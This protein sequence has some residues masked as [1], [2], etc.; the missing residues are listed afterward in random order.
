MYKYIFEKKMNKVFIGVSVRCQV[1][2]V[3]CHMCGVSPRTFHM[4]LMPTATAMDPPPA[5]GELLFSS[6]G[7]VKLI[8]GH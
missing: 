5:K 6:V 4:S 8:P 1:S 2:H 7:P 3:T